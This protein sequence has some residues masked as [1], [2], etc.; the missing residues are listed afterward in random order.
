[1]PS[2]VLDY[3]FRWKH[4]AATNQVTIAPGVLHT[5]TINRADNDAGAIITIYDSAAGV[6]ANNI[7][8]IICLDKAVYVIPATLAYDCE[9]QNGL[10]VAFAAGMAEA[11]I[12]ISYR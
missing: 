10:Y 11:D 8:A 3:P 6:D 12:T 9:L 1:M 5:V 7:I 4:L 2:S